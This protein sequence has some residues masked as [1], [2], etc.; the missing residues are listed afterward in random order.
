MSAVSKPSAYP[1]WNSNAALVF[2]T[3]A[4]GVRSGGLASGAALP[5]AYANE[6]F[7]EYDKWIEYFDAIVSVAN[8]TGNCASADH[9]AIALP[10]GFTI[11]NCFVLGGTLDGNGDV[12]S[13]N[14]YQDG[15]A[16]FAFTRLYTSGGTDYLGLYH[17]TEF[18]GRA[19]KVVLCKFNI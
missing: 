16:Y 8:L 5:S 9:T 17:G 3:I 13:L 1:Q 19:Y 6:I 7:N 14:F 12:F 10:A 11:S 15:T 2:A 4:A 18:Y